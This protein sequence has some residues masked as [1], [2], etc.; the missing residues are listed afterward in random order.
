M[1]MK[2]IWQLQAKEGKF[3][4]NASAYA[5]GADLLLIVTGGKPHIGCVTFGDSTN[6]KA[7]L[8]SSGHKDNIANEIFFTAL[9]QFFSGNIAILGGIHYDQLQKQEIAQIL[10]LC[11]KL[12]ENLCENF[13][14]GELNVKNC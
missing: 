6:Y 3:T 9:K 14:N 5:I 12:A 10:N 11:Q 4:I 7:D 8:C 1:K 13:K 2:N